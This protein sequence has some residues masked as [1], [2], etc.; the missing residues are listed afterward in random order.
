MEHS[1]SVQQGG[2][3]AAVHRVDARQ[4]A[5]IDRVLPGASTAKPLDERR[6]FGPIV[7]PG[8]E[9]VV[10]GLF[11]VMIMVLLIDSRQFVAELVEFQLVHERLYL[12]VAL[13]PAG[14]FFIEQPVQRLI[15]ANQ[16]L[17]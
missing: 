3:P 2:A 13:E 10:L 15:L 12:A 5:A 14:E 9:G 7:E 4:I 6:V 17:Q 11:V 1:A 16:L 8:V